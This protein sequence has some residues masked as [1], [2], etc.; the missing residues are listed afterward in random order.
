VS[1]PAPDWGLSNRAYYEYATGTKRLLSDAVKRKPEVAFA[2]E[3]GRQAVVFDDDDVVR[4]LRAAIERE[5][6]QTAFAKR[7][8][9]ERTSI[10]TI[11]SRKRPVTAAVANALGLQRTYTAK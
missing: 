7:Y 4:L 9:I 3:I 8:G 11:L 1:V 5:G 6:S 2:G 10:N